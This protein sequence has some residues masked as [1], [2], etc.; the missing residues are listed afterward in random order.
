MLALSQ[1]WAKVL[2]S[3]PETGMGYQVCQIQLTDGRK[4]EQVTIVGGRVT[5]IGNSPVIPFSESEIQTI[6]VTRSK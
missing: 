3:Q 6:A 5:A 1:K 4:F 2:A